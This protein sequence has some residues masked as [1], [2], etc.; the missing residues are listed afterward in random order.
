MKKILTSILIVIA[1]LTIAV[2]VIFFFQGGFMKKTYLD[3]WEEDYYKN[4]SDPREQLIA[5]GIL[6]ANGHN[7][8][9]WKFKFDRNN[10]LAFD[11]YVEGERLAK[12]VDPFFTQTVISHG[13]LFEYMVIAG[14]Q[15][16]YNL[17]FEIFP[18][19]EF[20]KNISNDELVSKRVAHIE[21]DKAELKQNL[22]YKEMFKPDTSRVAYEKL[23]LLGKDINFLKDFK[24]K[25]YAQDI[26]FIYI[27][28][29]ENYNK[30]KK[31]VLE[32]A[33]K[34]I[35]TLRVMQE[36]S[37]IFRK[38]E[39]EKNKYG[40]GFSFEGSAITGFKMHLIQMLLTLF[41]S[42]NNIEASKK[43]FISQTG[44]ATNNNSGF[45]LL[46]VDDNTRTKQF[47]VGRI[48][49]DIQ[50]KAHTLG[51]A[52]QPMSQSIQEYEEM[53]DIYNEIHREIVK[54]EQT[55]LM[56]F[57]IGKPVSE[58]PKS[59]RRGLESFIQK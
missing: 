48:Y 28:E 2:L 15:L 12:E 33:T 42:M 47:N 18:D 50:L 49:S 27:N 37:E 41:P 54:E 57:R 13:T 51:L 4:F 29:G 45:I 21:L 59:M 14:E 30:V 26:E 55:I 3:P 6:A 32:G 10:D 11:L 56:L 52:V 43:S 22:L 5:H 19:G 25:D 34:E 17:K 7:M 23:N 1:I 20:S 44:M 35:E 46:V 53:K 24:Q 8:Q 40:Y 39:K 38:N 16:G 58:V 31:Y 9:N 36:A